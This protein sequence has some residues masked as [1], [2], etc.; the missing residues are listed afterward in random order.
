MKNAHIHASAD[1]VAKSL[2]RNWRAEHLFALKQAL[3][4]FD[5]IG[6]QLT[7]CDRKIEAQLKSLL[8]HDGELAKGKKRGRARNAPKFDLRTQLFKM[9]GVDLT[10]S[11][12]SMSPRHWR[13]S[14]KLE[15]A[16]IEQCAQCVYGKGWI[17]PM[18]HRM[19]VGADRTEILDWVNSV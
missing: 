14:A 7:Q 5:F 4:P 11:T 15:R 13:S 3:E 18:K 12:A 10:A 17:M 9:C 6:A 16:V 2:E 1:E 19:T 8:A